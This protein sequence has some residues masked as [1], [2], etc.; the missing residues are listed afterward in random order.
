[1][2][3][4][5]ERH[6]LQPFAEQ[7][8]FSSDDLA[9]FRKQ[10]I[11]SLKHFAKH[12]DKLFKPIKA[13]T[14]EDLAAF[15]GHRE[16]SAITELAL[17]QMQ[18][19]APVDDTLAAFLR[20]DGQLGDGVMFFFRE[21]LRQDGRLEK[22]QAALQQ[23]G[24]CLEIQ[25]LQENIAHLKA[26]QENSPYLGEQI[27]QQLQQMQQA[28]SA[29]QAR[30]DQLL[31]F[32][33]RFD[34]QTA[35]ILEW[36]K[37]VYGTLDQIKQKL[38]ETQEVVI[39]NNDILQ[40]LYDMM[41][42]R[43]ISSQVSPRDELTQYDSESLQLIQSAVEL[44]KQL[45]TQHPEYGQVS[46]KV[47]SAL[48][49]KGDLAQAE[50]L[51][52]Q[53]IKKAKNK[54]DQA[55]AC[56]N[57]FQVQWRKA[58]AET[59][60]SAKEQHYAEALQALQAAIKLSN[61]HYALH[62]ITTGYYPIEKILG[63]GGMGCALLCQNRNQLTNEKHKKVVVKCFWENIE[64][65][66]D[67]VFKEP[68]AM[69]KIAGDCVP[70]PLGVGYADN[71]NKKR[72]YFVT[73]Y[74]EGAI[75]GEAW[76]EEYG[77]LDCGLQVGLEIAKGLQRAHEKGIYH[78]DLKPANLLLKRTESGIMVKIIDFG[79]SRVTT[80][81]R[82]VAEQR[83]RTGLTVF[84]QAM[85]GTAEYAPPEQRGYARHY[86]EVPGAKSDIF[87]FGKTM[88]RLLT[89]ELPFAVEHE[90]LEHAPAWYKLLSDCV[91]QNPEKRPESVGVLVSR[92]EGIERVQ[93]KENM[94][95]NLAREREQRQ[96]AE[97]ER[98]QQTNIERK[99]QEQS[100][101]QTVGKQEIGSPVIQTLI[102]LG[103]IGLGGV[104][105]ALSVGIFESNNISFLGKYAEE[106]SGAI[107][108]LLLSILL[109]GQ[110]LWRHRQTIPHLAMTFGLIGVGWAIWAAIIVSVIFSFPKNII[111][112]LVLTVGL[113]LPILLVGQYRWRHRQTMPRSA[114]IT[115]ILNIVIWS[116]FLL[117]L[118][119]TTLISG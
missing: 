77:P 117:L 57:L 22:T 47:G 116:F 2:P 35:E 85:F 34:I 27:T 106:A 1:L 99:V 6:Y 38:G 59:T 62:D 21:L 63:A 45:P 79:L 42:Q 40:K 102:V 82:Q 107:V 29:W 113:S 31:R 67:T 72:P 103:L 111:S 44:L 24:L 84:G 30:Q 43:G 7:Q 60:V 90:P 16:T 114:V 28:Q 88:Y 97:N 94:S 41:A 25:K 73:E 109:V 83:S 3:K 110:Y 76:L 118:L 14:E 55:L 65:A 81:L 98:K 58:F 23:E 36:A 95:K 86:G 12:T 10:A 101:Q 17:E 112:I 89:G 100:V 50:Q 104:L 20:F 11:E 119:M 64:G 78:L 75:D 70:Q 15:I 19:I 51:F 93:I 108:G 39:Q 68:F 56:F 9:A 18:R 48:S 105:T 53:A 46:L 4:K 71:L 96:K 91:R 52:V 87:A 66:L 32:S 49:S 33:R 80:S 61:G 115:V 69:H 5:I 37:D 74:V 92:L 8:G 13:L 26:I 54:D